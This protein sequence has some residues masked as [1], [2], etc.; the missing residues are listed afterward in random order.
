MAPT[1]D[2]T[3]VRPH[4]LARLNEPYPEHVEP[5]DADAGAA[6]GVNLPHWT[7]LEAEVF[8]DFTDHPSYG[9]G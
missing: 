2:T 9:I 5:T 6:I 1:D 3:S 7:A 8:P 4:D